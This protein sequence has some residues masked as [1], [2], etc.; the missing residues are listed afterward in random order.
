MNS[1][2]LQEKPFQSNLSFNFSNFHNSGVPQ[3]CYLTTGIVFID[4][5][6]D[7]YEML[8]AGVK[9]GL[10]VVLL[11]ARLDGIAQITQEMT[12]RRGLSSLHILAHG[13]AG[14]LWLGKEVVDSNTLE[15]YR[16]DL[17]SWAAAFAPDADILLY[18]CNVAAGETGQQFV[19]LLGQLT[20][21]D[22]AASNNLTGSAALGGD[23][24]LE[25]KIG[26]VEAPIAFG[27]ETMEAYKAVLTTTRISVGTGDPGRYNDS[28]SASISANGRYVAFQSNATNL[29]S[30]DTNSRTDIFV[31]DT[32]AN[33]TRRVSVD[34]N[35]TQGNSFS[36][37]PSISADGRYVAFDSSASNLVSD[38]TNSARDIFVYDT[39]ANTTRRVSVNS[40]GTQGN[41]NS[42]SSSISADGRYVAFYSYASNLVSGDTNRSTDIFVYDTVAN[43]TRRVS[44]DS[45]G[46]QGNDNSFNPS[47]SADGH[48]V[49]FHSY[50]TN[51]VSDDTNNAADIFIYDTAANTTRRVSVGT[52]DTE[53]NSYSFNPSLSADG[54]YVAFSSGASNLVSDDT[55]NV[56]DIF[57][58]DTVANTTR[59]VSVDSNGIEGNGR[60]YNPS[61]SAD[62][63]YVAFESASSNLVSDD[64]NNTIDIFVYDTVANT[65]RRVSV[66]SNGIEGNSFSY[67]PSISVDG[68]VVFESGASNLVS[69]DTNNAR[70]IF[71]YDSGTANVTQ[72]PWFGT[73]ENDSYTYTASDNFT[74]YGLQGNDTITGGT[75]NDIFVGGRGDDI[76]LGIN[77]DDYLI[78]GSGNDALLGGAGNDILDGS[79]FWQDLDILTGGAGADTFVLGSQRVYYRG[80]GYANIT[81]FN[82]SEGDTIQVLGN[83]SQYQV[84]Q[85]NSPTSPVPFTEI[86]YVGNGFGNELIGVVQNSIG[87]NLERDFVFV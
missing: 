53:G 82:S 14:K 33:T 23:W 11:D 15:Q 12:G 16:D 71:L 6:V 34:S 66:D 67:A 19:Q 74:G 81:D 25:V 58:Y 18:G 83:S 52:G 70:D 49:A 68:R 26:N 64:T 42:Y 10:E 69:D 86:Y 29:V 13:E 87:V 27:I 50:A 57:V 85:V 63:R 76:L 54:R 48:Y 43:T 30:D 77:G 2:L 1:S 80:D 44:V 45:N 59:R 28:F 38:D 56:E 41:V 5:K 47:L 3:P 73:P 37:D 65:T 35:G 39:V 21:A 60:C 84:R 79:G 22:V 17:H 46:I 4:P 55:N 9:P 7:D 78:G 36:Y 20:G 61:L 51:L 31:Y 40:N 24:E 32:V 75:G 62:G 72:N 8:M